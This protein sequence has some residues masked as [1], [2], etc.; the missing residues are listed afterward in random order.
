MLRLF[1]L[2]GLHRRWGKILKTH[3]GIPRESKGA[4]REGRGYCKGDGT[5]EPLSRSSNGSFSRLCRNSVLQCCYIASPQF[6]TYSSKNISFEKSSQVETLSLFLLVPKVIYFADAKSD[7]F[8]TGSDIARFR[9]SAIFY[10]PK[11]SRSGYH[12]A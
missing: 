11:N 7:I 12:S 10:S 8:L 1:F 9:L 2:S 3:S 5:T 4:L 6:Q